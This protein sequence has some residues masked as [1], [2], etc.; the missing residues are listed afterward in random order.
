MYI[1]FILYL[2]SVQSVHYTVECRVQIN[3]EQACLVYLIL[4]II[5]LSLLESCPF[6]GGGANRFGGGGGLSP[7]SPNGSYG[8][9]CTNVYF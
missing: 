6:G 5:N 4:I 7:I 1:L 3:Y 2:T 8:P 9:A